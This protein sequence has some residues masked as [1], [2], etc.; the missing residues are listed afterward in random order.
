MT[1]MNVRDSGGAIV[2]IEKPLVPGRAADIASRPVA[3][4][5][6]DVTLLGATNETAPA[7]DTATVGLN[8][9]LQRIAQN[10]T[11]F[12]ALFPG[13]LAGNGGLKVG[14]PDVRPA[15]VNITARDIVSSSASGQNAVG[16]VTG[17]PTANSTNSQAINGEST[18]RIQITG[19]WTGT[20]AFEG[21]ADGGTTWF[22]QPARGTGTV[23]TLGSVTGNG[24]FTVDVSGLTNL[25]VRSTAVMTGIAVTQMTLATPAGF[26]Q[27]TNPVRIV[28][29][30]TGASETIKA[31]STPPATTDTTVVTGIAD[32]NNV[33]L[34]S[35][36]DAK[37]AT[38]DA[39][40]ITAMSV[41]KQISASVQA[42]VTGTVLAAGAALIGRTVADA[43]SAAGGITDTARLA[44]AAASTNALRV[45]NG[46]G[47]I[48]QLSG[49][50]NAAYDVFLV[51]Y[52]STTSPPVPGTTVIRKKIICPAGQAFVYDFANGLYFATG[53]GYAFTKLVA[54][55]DTTV[56]VAA[57]ITAFNMDYC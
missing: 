29:N 23:Y 42:L 27:V 49:K 6:E 10:I 11:A 24:L 20:L 4:S 35:K 53:I 56:L 33:T 47:R 30:T 19:T 13:A 51:L 9:R 40:P 22:A 44:S 45:K 5:N 7:S 31:A 12:I 32:G 41:W 50:N 21:S 17:A 3:L 38:T 37:A 34:G 14:L 8:G 48:Y 43:S 2:A 57:D 26:V 36:A 16:I 28:D 39:T 1:T 46:A 15:A 54:D 55:A 52:D 25:R 18:A